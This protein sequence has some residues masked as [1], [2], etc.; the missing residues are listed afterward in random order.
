MNVEL[1]E[2]NEPPSSLPLS[3]C[4]NSDLTQELGGDEGG[5]SLTEMMKFVF[6]FWHGNYRNSMFVLLIINNVGILKTF[7]KKVAC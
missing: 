3:F 6:Q 2:F 4:L 5:L 7:Q 1:I